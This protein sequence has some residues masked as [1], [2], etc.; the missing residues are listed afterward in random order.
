MSAMH[1]CLSQ[2]RFKTP[3]TTGFWTDSDIPVVMGVHVTAG[4]SKP[5]VIRKDHC[6]FLAPPAVSS[7]ANTAHLCLKPAVTN[8]GRQ[9][10]VN[11]YCRLVDQA[12]SVALTNTVG[13]WLKLAVFSC[14]SLLACGS[15]RQWYLQQ[16]CGLVA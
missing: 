12:N 3:F 1:H 4:N 6:R 2:C 5:L 13:S 11:Q 8:T 14:P 7:W 10:S 9:C 15:S 16:H